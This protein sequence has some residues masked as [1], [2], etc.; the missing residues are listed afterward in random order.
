MSTS[1]NVECALLALNSER[2]PIEPLQLPAFEVYDKTVQAR[3]EVGRSP[4][5]PYDSKESKKKKSRWGPPFDPVKDL[6][7]NPVPTTKNT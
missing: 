2:L 6:N 7:L 5:T 1:N 4:N 3:K